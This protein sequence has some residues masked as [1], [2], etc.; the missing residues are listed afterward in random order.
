MGEAVSTLRLY[1][2]RGL[3]LLNFL[4]VGGGVLFEFLHRHKPWDPITGCAFSLWAALAVLS[5]VGIRYPLAML[6]LLFMQLCYKAFWFPL[7][8]FPLRAAGGSS[9]L[10]RGFLIAIALDLVAIPW[11]YVFANYVTRSGDRW[12]RRAASA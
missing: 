12:D 11:T 1:I 10:A 2:L 8:Y 9:D 5:A 3:Y 4:L 6:P 7:T